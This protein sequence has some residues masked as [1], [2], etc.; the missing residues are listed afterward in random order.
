VRWG[1]TLNLFGRVETDAGLV[2]EAGSIV[3]RSSLNEG[4]RRAR[5]ED[6]GS[7][8]V[9]DAGNRVLYMRTSELVQRLQAAR[10]GLQLP[11]ALAKM[12]LEHR[13]GSATEMAYFRSDLLEERRYLMEDWA[14]W[15]AGGYTGRP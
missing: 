8:S 2:P 13:I 4:S 10:K 6:H 1:T 3:S 12:A 9:D 7:P 11:Q 5:Q 14:G 15:C